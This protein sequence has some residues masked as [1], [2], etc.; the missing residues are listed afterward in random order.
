MKKI[1]KKTKQKKESLK[2][3][4]FIFETLNIFLVH[5]SNREVLILFLDTL[6]EYLHELVVCELKG[7]TAGGDELDYPDDEPGE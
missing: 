3:L 2:G 7:V 1:T 4:Y 5:A 6:L